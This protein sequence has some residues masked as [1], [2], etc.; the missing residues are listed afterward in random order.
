MPLALSHKNKFRGIFSQR[1]IV[2]DTIKLLLDAEDDN[3]ESRLLI[4]C[5]NGQIKF[6][7]ENDIVD[8]FCKFNYALLCR[9]LKS[10][11]RIAIF[12][13]EGKENLFTV[14]LTPINEIFFAASEIPEGESPA[15][16]EIEEKVSEV[17]KDTS[18]N[19]TVSA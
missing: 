7:K 15:F 18:V 3:F 19:Q 17:S 13:T 2:Y 8:R 14:W 4:R 12:D 5:E 6:E 1:E 11:S 16:I 9:E 10:Q